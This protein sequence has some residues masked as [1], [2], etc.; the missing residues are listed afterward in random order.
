MSYLPSKLQPAAVL[1]KGTPNFAELLVRLDAADIA[2]TRKRDFAS[3]LR[4]IAYTLG[5]PLDRTY[6]HA[7]WLQPRLAQITAQSVGLAPKTWSN[8]ISNLRGAIETLDRT[9]PRV[10]R[11][12][13]LSPDWRALFELMSV[14][15]TTSIRFSISGFIFFLS[16]IGVAPTEV[17]SDHAVAYRDELFESQLRKDPEETYRKSVLGWN[18]MGASHAF[19]PQQKLTSP[20]RQK[21]IRPDKGVLP[22]TFLTDLDAYLAS[23][24]APDVLSDSGPKRA[25]RPATIKRRKDRVLM[26]AGALIRDG[27]PAESLI[28]LKALVEVQNVRRGLTWLF[29]QNDEQPIMSHRSLS[30]ALFLIAR[31]H[32]KAPQGELGELAKF[33]RN[34]KNKFPR[35]RGMTEKNYERIRV[36]RDKAALA[37]LLQLPERLFERGMKLKDKPQGLILI[38]DAVMLAVLRNH[39]IR[40]MNLINLRLEENI[41]RMRSG[42]AYLVFRRKE[43]KNKNF[44]EFEIS[45]ALLVMIDAFVSLRP[46]SNW[47]FPSPD[48]DKP[49]S[50]GYVSMRVKQII[51]RELGFDV[52][53]HLARHLAAFVF[54]ENKPG[55][56]EEVRRLLG[57]SSTGVTLDAY[58]GFET[59]AVGRRYSEMIEQIRHKTPPR[60]KR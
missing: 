7:P 31:D 43:V 19:W 21:K 56:Y 57:H 15:D 35:T 52:N 53:A 4:R 16:R 2:P 32:V 29:A 25:L 36:F 17:N 39:A 1:P 14:A 59:D 45:P 33:A 13:D 24:K 23:L 44:L 34:L 40:R 30:D 50:D 22:H 60:K 54:L 27:V 42:G 47:L 38:R 6:A 46:A 26:F 8:M 37:K 20:S 11:R 18:R 51:K 55:H 58:A 12:K 49:L 9:K 3:A 10:N 28:T 48:G 5:T 41:D